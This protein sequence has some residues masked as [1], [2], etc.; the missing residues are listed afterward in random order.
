MKQSIFDVPKMDCP[1]E[2]KLIRLTFAG[3]ESI[4]KL[5][6]DLP[7]R[8]LTIVHEND[9]QDVLKKLEPLGFGAKLTS[10]SAI[11]ID[12]DDVL[13]L[14]KEVESDP[15]EEKVLIQLL[16]I[17]LTMFFVEITM[18]IFAHSAGLI[19]DSMDMFADAAVYGISLYAVGKA[20]ALQKSAARISGYLQLALAVFAFSEVIRRFIY[21]S[22]PQAG[23]MVGISIIALIANVICLL[24]ISKQRTGKVH[25]EASY[26]FSTNDVI[27]NAGVIIAGLLV[28]YF[29]SPIPDLVIG[30]VI[31]VVVIKGAIAILKISK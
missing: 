29:K 10:T 14:A 30:F 1:S 3:I 6:F 19:S 25:M 18:G 11:E 9:A 13:A 8:K 27:A 5:E 4:K 31:A 21:G 20:V 26:I 15:K 24:L 22:E 2:E 12:S 28:G 16:V 7:Q 23:Y 17:N